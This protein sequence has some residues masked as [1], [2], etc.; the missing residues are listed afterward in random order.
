MLAVVAGE[1]TV[2]VDCGVNPMIKLQKNGIDPSLVKHLIITHFH[3]DHVSGFPLFLMSLWLQGRKDE[4]NV[5]GIGHTI[6]R[7]KKMM[8]LFGWEKW[9]NFYPVEFHTIAE[10]NSQPVLETDSLSVSGTVVR[11]FIP[12]M[13]VRFQIKSNGYQVGYT[14]DTEPCDGVGIVADGVDMLLHEATGEEIGHS[15]AGQAGKAAQTAGVSHLVLVHY[16]TENTPKM[17]MIAEATQFFTGKITCAD[18]MQVFEL[19]GR[20]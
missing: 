12:T 7:L 14:C 6:E 15:S 2:L 9:P 18:D 1:E 13:G 10:G 8:D 3:P 4:L 17:D 16:P 11:H 20:L 5:Y 19:S